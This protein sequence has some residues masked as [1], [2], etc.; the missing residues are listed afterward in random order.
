MAA[1]VAGGLVGAGGLGALLRSPGLL[2]LDREKAS[3]VSVAAAV[4]MI[5]EL[6]ADQA[7][8]RQRLDI[9]ESQYARCEEERA[10]DRAEA[11]AEIR[12]LKRQLRSI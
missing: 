8:L 12:E 4:K 2:R 1:V 6:Q 5:R 9:A 11:R 7:I 3:D 10:A